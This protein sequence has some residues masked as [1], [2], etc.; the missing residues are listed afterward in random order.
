MPSA[1]CPSAPTSRSSPTNHAAWVELIIFN[2]FRA[3]G[4]PLRACE[5][6]APA[7]VRPSF[8]V[9][10]KHLKSLINPRIFGNR[11][12]DP[13]PQFGAGSLLRLHVCKLTR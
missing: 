11:R 6:G 8:S 3:E 4:V 12:F 7:V 2:C 13:A 1:R 5:Q 9:K 10:R